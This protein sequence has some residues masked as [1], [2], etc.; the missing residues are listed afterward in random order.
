MSYC[1]HPDCQ[2][3]QN[4]NDAKFCQ[5]CGSK[6]LL[7]ERYRAIKPIGAGGFGRTFV[8]VDEMKPSQP[9]CVIKQFFPQ[10]QG[11]LHSVK[12]AELFRQEAIRLDVLGKHP[13]IPELLAHFEQGQQQYLVQEFV[14]GHNLAEELAESG[15]FNEKQIRQLLND[16]LPVLQ[17]VHTNQLIHRDIK[18]EN[19]IRRSADRQLVLVDFGAAKFVNRTALQRTGTVIGSAAYTAP[20]QLMGKAVFASDLYSL[21]VTC[22]HLLTQ[23]P[24][25]DLFDSREGTWAWR[26]YLGQIVSDPLGHI[27]D[28]LLQPAINRRYLSA[29]QVIKALNPP[30]VPIGLRPVAAGSAAPAML[31]PAVK[32]LPASVPVASAI[33]PKPPIQSRRTEIQKVLQEALNPY[34]VKVQVSLAKAQLTIVINREEEHKV[35]YFEVTR[36]IQSQLNE[37][38]LNALERVK[39]FG[40]VNKQSTPEWQKVLKV[41]PLP[42]PVPIEPE[43]NLVKTSSKQWL[44]KVKK[45]AFL[46]DVLIFFTI[47]AIFNHVIIFSP[48]NAIVLAGCFMVVKNALNQAKEIKTDKLFQELVATLLVVSLFNIRLLVTGAVGILFTCLFVGVPFLYVK[49]NSGLK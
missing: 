15:A 7:G 17:F 9:R 32:S 20:E 29:A 19:I 13:Q 22:V 42:E 41:T 37:L 4:T 35:N 31:K 10:D 2:K 43:E 39:V 11:F 40:R 27:L 28:K 36:V 47:A 24:P 34:E 25:F 23:M 21:G 45:P 18:P 46:Q 6:I 14:D 48:Q 1:L 38:Q 5:S 16:L 49:Q 12:A 26:D 33:V 44:E 30:P 3:P 8:A